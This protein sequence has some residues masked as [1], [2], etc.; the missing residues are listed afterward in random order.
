MTVR[1]KSRV[2][3]GDY[4][5]EIVEGFGAE[6]IIADAAGVTIDSR[7]R[8]YVLNRSEQEPVLV[9]NPSGELLETWGAGLFRRAH[10]IFA[11]PDD[12]I[13]C[14]DDQGH[15]LRKF[16]PEGKLLFEIDTSDSPADTGYIPG[17]PDSVA[18][19]GPPFN[20]PTGVA[21]SPEGEIVVSDGYG[22]ARIHRFSS[23]GELISS[24][25][26]PGYGDGQLF[27]PHG[28]AIDNEGLIYVA[29]RENSRVQVF[30]PDGSL[31]ARWR[32]PRASCLW[33]EGDILFV[34]EMGEVI[35]GEPGNKRL[36]LENARASVTVRKKDGNILSE[37]PALDPEGDG[38]FFSPHSI[39]RDSSGNLYVSEVSDS[40]SGG[41]APEDRSKVNKYVLQ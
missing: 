30:S 20:T 37:L 33:I 36:V 41:L 25:G 17:K 21:L 22:N 4:V 18:R 19:A 39:A 15:A 2:G 10:A 7:D 40:Y 6:W 16:T 8:V 24:F 9:F 31:R 28:V 13:Y 11:G 5:Y 3:S 14:V 35:Q 34:T 32:S 23:D 29:D 1:G 12:A 38:L 27:L 26:E